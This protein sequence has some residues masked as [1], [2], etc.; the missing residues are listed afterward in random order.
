MRELS[1]DLTRFLS[2]TRGPFHYGINYI[3]SPHTHADQESGEARLLAARVVT[4]DLIEKGVPHS[5]RL[6]TA[7]ALANSCDTAPVDGWYEFDLHFLALAEG[8]TILELARVG[9]QPGHPAG[10]A[11]AKA[12]TSRSNCWVGEKSGHS[13]RRRPSGPW[14]RAGRPLTGCPLGHG[15][16]PVQP[17]RTPVAA[18]TAGESRT[19][20]GTVERCNR[21]KFGK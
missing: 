14:S 19:F 9:I 17:G 6:S 8:M 11:F 5:A 7:G 13:W 12:R 21:R 16:P 10:I 4:S 1:S 3:A 15:G 20:A 2:T 18:W